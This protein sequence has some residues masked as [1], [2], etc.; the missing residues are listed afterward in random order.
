MSYILNEITK[1]FS[2]KLVYIMPIKVSEDLFSKIPQAL[3][4]KSF[5]CCQSNTLKLVSCSDLHLLYYE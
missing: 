1:L 4:I 2:R 5:S 3:V